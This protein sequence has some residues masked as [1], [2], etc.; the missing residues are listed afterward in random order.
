MYRPNAS[1]TSS[2]VIARIRS[3]KNWN[4]CLLFYWRMDIWSVDTVGSS[5][6]PESEL[7]KVMSADRIRELF[8]PLLDTVW[9]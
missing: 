8:S 3:R 4:D 6:M 9:L 2:V 1:K 5:G 7:G